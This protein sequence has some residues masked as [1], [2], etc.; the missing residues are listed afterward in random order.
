MEDIDAPW[1]AQHRIRNSGWSP[2]LG[3]TFV[4]R[5]DVQIGWSRNETE[6]P[7]RE[8]QRLVDATAALTRHAN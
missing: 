4:L 6:H 5:A 7:P 3:D 8:V 2:T 1:K